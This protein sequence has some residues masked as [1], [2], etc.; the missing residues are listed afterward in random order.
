MGL[1]GNC[2]QSLV[3][4]ISFGMKARKH[5]KDRCKNHP[6]CQHQK[7]NTCMCIFFPSLFLIYFFL[8]VQ[9]KLGRFSVIINKGD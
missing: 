7:P 2:R 4:N 5:A 3:G 1:L 8:R 9:D 6:V